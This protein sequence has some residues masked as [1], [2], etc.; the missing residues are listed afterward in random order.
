MATRLQLALPI[1]TVHLFDSTV[2]QTQIDNNTVLGS[3][4]DRETLTSFLEDAE[5]EFREVTNDAM[6]VSRVGVAGQRE[7]FESATHK[8][9]GHQLTKGTF[10]GTWTQY[11]PDE[12]HIMLDNQRVLP[13]DSTAGDAV[14]LYQ[15]LAEDGDGW[16]EVTDKQG[17]MWDILDPVE[18]RFVFSPIEVAED[19]LTGRPTARGTVPEF[20]KRIRFAVSYRHG[21]LGG[22]RA[23]ATA[24]DLDASLSAGQTG[25][26]AVDDGAQFPTGTEAGPIIVAVGSEYMSVVPDPANDQMDI[27]ARGVRN[28][29]DVSHDSGDTVRYTPPAVR[30]A[31]AAQ[32]GMALIQSGRYQS[33]LPDSE[34][35]IDRSDLMDRMQTIWSTT[36][37]VLG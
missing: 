32:A 13:F 21:T 34:D 33:F 5:G 12:Q 17:D 18:G 24:T 8:L 29:T 23:R 15:G 1:D 30:K 3:A 37:E 7:T 36:T 6:Q 25:T 9:S 35:A 14:Y 2:T 26:I 19:I 4:D 27:Q 11:L 31:V 16:L 28:T 10:T 20:I 22:N